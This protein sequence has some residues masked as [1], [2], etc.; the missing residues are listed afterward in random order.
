MGFYRVQQQLR[1]CT[2]APSDETCAVSSFDMTGSTAREAGQPLR[3]RH[4]KQRDG[5]GARVWARLGPRMDQ[6]SCMR[7]I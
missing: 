5:H 6:T 2:E 4:S 3:A 7:N 1:R